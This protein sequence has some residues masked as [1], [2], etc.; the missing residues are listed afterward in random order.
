METIY[1]FA[2]QFTRK[3]ERNK[4]GYVVIDDISNNIQLGELF[5]QYQ[6]SK[7]L[8]GIVQ[9]SQRHQHET[10]LFIAVAFQ[11]VSLSQLCFFDICSALFA[12]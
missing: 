7:T 10:Q 6:L 1:Q 3:D 12:V 5:R 2:F 4:I 11:F 9:S 8:A